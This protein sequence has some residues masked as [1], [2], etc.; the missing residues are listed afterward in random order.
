MRDAL[1]R[2][3]NVRLVPCTKECRTQAFEMLQG[4]KNCEMTRL[5]SLG[6]CIDAQH[7]TRI[8]CCAAS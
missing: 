1:H 7:E 3:N 5:I 8:N 6:R 4:L 2:T